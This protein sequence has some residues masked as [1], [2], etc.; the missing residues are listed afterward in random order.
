MNKI[1]LALQR[2]R[3]TKFCALGVDAL[4]KAPSIFTQAFKGAK[5]IIIADT[6]T[7]KAAGEAVQQEFEC[8]HICCEDPY[9]IY[10]PSLYAEWSFVEGLYERLS[11]TDAIAVAVGSGTINDLCKYV[12]GTL[13]RKYMCCGTAASMDGYTSYGASITKDGNKQTFDCPAPYAT[14]IDTRIVAA[15]P[16]YLAASGYAD[17]IAKIPAGADWM[18]ADCVGAEPIDPFAW[19]LVQDGLAEAVSQ[20]SA[21][22]SGDLQATEGLCEGLLLSGFAMQAIQSSRPAS[23][24]EHQF[25]HAWDM[26]ALAYPNGLHVSHGFKVGI[27]TLVSTRCLEGLISRDLQNLDIDKCVAS[28]PTWDYQ[29][30]EIRRLCEGKPAHLERCLSESRDKYVG[31]EALRERLLRVRNSWP[32]LRERLHGQI[33]PYSQVLEDLKAV[34]APYEC[35]QICVSKEHLRETYDLVPYMRSRYTSIDLLYSIGLLDL[36]R[37]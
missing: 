33:L 35:E 7:W 17:L 10:D 36:L 14:V 4:T 34:G 3:D 18:I 27:G 22:R 15:A 24:M 8:A 13:G 32:E 12:S 5:A 29:E 9:I 1:E 6:N 23:G 11:Q 37:P 25:S 31:K 21:V 2:T 16:K 30:Q 28:Y 19:H 26:E 20:P